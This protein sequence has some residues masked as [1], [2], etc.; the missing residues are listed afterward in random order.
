[1]LEMAITRSGQ[2]E[3]PAQRCSG[4]GCYQHFVEHD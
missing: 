3:H 4:L 2:L 1:M